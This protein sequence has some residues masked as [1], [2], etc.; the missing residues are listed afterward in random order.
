M[1]D[2]SAEIEAFWKYISN[3]CISFESLVLFL[4]TKLCFFTYQEVVSGLKPFGKSPEQES[5]AFW[6]LGIRLY[7]YDPQKSLLGINLTRSLTAL[8]ALTVST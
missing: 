4:H 7:N 6:N 8:T 5:T 3:V 1:S 2:K